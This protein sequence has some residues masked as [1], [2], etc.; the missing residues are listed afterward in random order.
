[1]KRFSVVCA[2]LCF[3][4]GSVFAQQSVWNDRFVQA[5]QGNDMAALRQAKNNGANVNYMLNGR[6]AL[7]AAASNGNNQMVEVL[8]D[9]MGAAP[10]L[11]NSSGDSAIMF[12]VDKQNDN[13]EIVNML[14]ARNV[15]VNSRNVAGMTPLMLAIQNQND[16]MVDFLLSKYASTNARSTD[17]RDVL[18]HAVI[19]DNLFAV[20]KLLQQASVNTS[21]EDFGGKTAFIYAV[22]NQKT[23]IVRAFLSSGRFDVN[24][25]AGN[26][27]PPLLHAIQLKVSATIIEDILNN[28]D[29]RGARD[30]NNRGISEYFNN[31]RSTDQELRKLLESKGVKLDV[32]W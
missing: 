13:R 11:A 16:I 5:A 7:M 30:S 28:S 12:A 4:A 22:E 9:E 8:L 31:Y 1:M 6:T 2:A 3:V 25:P 26:G 19:E 17:G 24:K 14:L 32:Q 20:R 29:F 21:Q 23:D 15:N 10:S 27:V 18:I